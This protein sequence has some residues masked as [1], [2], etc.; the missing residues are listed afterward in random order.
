MKTCNTW[1][2]PT[3]IYL[4]LAIFFSQPSY[5]ASPSIRPI[6]IESDH[7]YGSIEAPVSIIMYS[8]FFCPYCKKLR[9]TLKKLVNQ[10][11]GRINWVY[12]H[13]PLEGDDSTNLR[14]A[15]AIE[16]TSKMY[17]NE[18]FWTLTQTLFNL[19]Q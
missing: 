18:Q 17:G 7:I 11:S 4:V 1:T 19:P 15:N 6:S 8:D 16:C 3:L 14:Q 10:S 9:L 2:W 12:R 13:F 5:S